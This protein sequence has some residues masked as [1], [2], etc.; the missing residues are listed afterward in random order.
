MA[1]ILR[2]LAASAV[3]F[4]ASTWGLT[5]V[6][7]APG[8]PMPSFGLLRYCTEVGHTHIHGKRHVHVHIKLRSLKEI[9]YE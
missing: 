1:Q 4:P 6:T 5:T 3:Q 9:A 7:P 8:D 2:A